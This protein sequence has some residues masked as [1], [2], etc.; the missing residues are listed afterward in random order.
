MDESP[1]MTDR[2]W[3]ARNLPMPP[4][5]MQALQRFLMESLL[6]AALIHSYHVDALRDPQLRMDPALER[7][8][9]I[10]VNELH[11]QIAALGASLRLQ[12]GD[13]RAMNSLGYNLAGFLENRQAALQ[14]S[15][16]L[17]PRTRQNPNVQRLMP[18]VQQS[19]QMVQQNLPVLTQAIQ[20]SGVSAT[21]GPLLIGRPH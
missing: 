9:L 10:E 13:P 20:A 7:F 5:T 6:V 8:N 17:S 1:Y 3:D 15:R 14:A 2:S 4:E 12:Q 19:N 18:L 21:P 16:N 11:H